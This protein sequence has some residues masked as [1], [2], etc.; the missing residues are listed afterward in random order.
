[1]YTLKL[2]QPLYTKLYVKQSSFIKYHN[3]FIFLNWFSKERLN[4]ARVKNSTSS[5]T[6]T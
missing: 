2:F 4:L 5:L 6:K 1:M 3:K